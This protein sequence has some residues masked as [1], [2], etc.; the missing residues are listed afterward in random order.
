M[1]RIGILGGTFDPPHIGHLILAEVA[2]NSLDL[3]RV[4]WAVAADPPHKQGLSITPVAHRLKMVELAISGS[5]AFRVS[6]V[7]VERP[8]P[9]YTVDMLRIL[10]GEYPG[11]DLIFIIGGDSLA[12]LPHWHRPSEL[13]EAA[14]LAVLNRPTASIDWPTLEA[15]IPGLRE[16]VTLLHGPQI[17]VSG[18]DLRKRLRQ[19]QSVR[20]LV[21]ESVVSYIESNN[22]YRES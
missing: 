22:L 17:D 18:I 13:I 16:R 4:L 5:R 6:L 21:P 10:S 1:T 19:R 8:G 15:S 12:D 14:R 7:D 3:D 9:H 2:R 11:D 20:Y